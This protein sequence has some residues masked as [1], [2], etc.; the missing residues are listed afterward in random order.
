[1]RTVSSSND[2]SLKR[3]SGIPTSDPN[4]AAFVL[5]VVIGAAFGL[6]LGLIMMR[7][8]GGWLAVVVG[9]VVGTLAGALVGKLSIARMRRQSQ[10]DSVL[11]REIGVIDPE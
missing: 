2:D 9:V 1:M 11:D 10:R 3:V 6:L 7:A 5:S 8:A 4:R